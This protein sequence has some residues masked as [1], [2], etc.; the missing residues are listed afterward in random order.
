MTPEI[1]TRRVE[2][3]DDPAAEAGLAGEMLRQ[4]NRIVIAG[5]FGEADDV[6]VLDGLADR[7][8]HADRE[9][10]EII[11]LKRRLLHE[12]SLY[13]RNA[14]IAAIGQSEYSAKRRRSS[15]GSADASS[16]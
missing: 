2:A 13:G 4:V 15:F 11:G 5:Q 9:F 12:V 1:R 3:M 16:A 7:L 14:D 6:L 10:V 8:A